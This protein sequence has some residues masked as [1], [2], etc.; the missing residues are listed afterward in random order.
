MATEDSANEPDQL[1]R[2]RFLR[3]VG[4]ASA[5]GAAG[6]GALGAAIVAGAAA[7]AQT[8]GAQPERLAGEL[9][10][11]LDINGA[12]RKFAVEPR[13]TLKS[14]LRDRLDPALT[15]TKLVCDNGNCGACTVLIDGE[16][17]YA[18]L[19]LAVRAR[20]RKVTTIEGV[21]KDG[22]LSALQQSFCE[23][24]ALMCGFCTPGFV[25]SISACL[26]KKPGASLD[27]I[28]HACAGNLCRCGTYPHILEAALGVARGATSQGARSAEGGAR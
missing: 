7:H 27:E 14:A 21:A 11:E 19:T 24:D 18:C 4:T 8:K 16:P 5:V 22:Q 13:T 23:H 1:S 9:E 28:K 17:V 12:A 15:G 3:T 10:I 25:M 26:A 6:G 20:G 2:R